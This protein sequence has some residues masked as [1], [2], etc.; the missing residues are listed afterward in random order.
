MPLLPVSSRA[1]I[2]FAA[3]ALACSGDDAH[4]R[5]LDG[6]VLGGGS[7]GS[8]GSAT[9]GGS[10]QPVGGAAGGAGCLCTFANGLNGLDLALGCWKRIR[11]APEV[12][13]CGK[14]AEDCGGVALRCTLVL[15]HD[16]VLEAQSFSSCPNPR[17]IPAGWRTPT[18][19]EEAQLASVQACGE[20][21]GG[22]SVG[23][24]GGAGGGSP[25]CTPN[26][27]DGAAGAVSL[28]PQA[29][30]DGSACPI[31]GFDL[32]T[33]AGAFGGG[34]STLSR[35]ALGKWQTIEA[36]SGCPSTYQECNW[37]QGWPANDGACCGGQS[38]PAANPSSGYGAR[39]CQGL[40]FCDGV[41]WYK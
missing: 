21:A 26:E 40:G 39:Y 34:P 17:G 27:G 32:C 3:F 15:E 1:L 6:A 35:C 38:G 37:P 24:A 23:G 31:E 13:F 8:S 14:V 5:D 10:G 20:N 7:G 29:P 9:G 19:A 4:R 11:E 12:L 2:T 25:A 36:P 30:P 22:G 16:G 18:P 41:R 33:R 28:P